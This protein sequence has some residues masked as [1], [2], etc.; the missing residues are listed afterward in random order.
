M[1][2]S[3]RDSGAAASLDWWGALSRSCESW[4]TRTAGRQAVDGRAAARA[5]DLI[6]F[7]RERSPF[8]RDAWRNLSPGVP[9]L[10]S[11]P[12]VTKR[13]LMAQFD[14]WVTDRRVDRRSVEAFIADRSHIGNRYLGRY[15][16]W[17]SSGSTGEPGIFVQDDG[18]LA[19]Y[20]AMLAL[21]LHVFTGDLCELRGGASRWVDA[22]AA[23]LD[24]RPGTSVERVEVPGAAV[25]PAR[26]ALVP[27]R[28]A[29]RAWGWVHSHS[30]WRA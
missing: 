9:A 13:A 17:K 30:C 2:A 11:L 18:A 22:V 7:A 1:H 4:W 6:A 15:V 16:V 10:S 14:D 27:P 28:V 5:A 24:V 21:Q 26:E 8:Y 19:V 3:N 20:D 29:M 25:R 12:I 23:D